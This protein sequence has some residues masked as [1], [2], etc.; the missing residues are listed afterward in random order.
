MVLTLI[1]SLVTALAIEGLGKEDALSRDNLQTQRARVQNKE[2]SYDEKIATTAR[3]GNINLPFDKGCSRGEGFYFSTTGMGCMASPFKPIPDCEAVDDTTPQACLRLRHIGRSTMDSVKVDSR[4]S[5]SK[6]TEMMASVEGGAFGVKASAS[7][8]AQARSSMTSSTIS[9][10]MYGQKHFGALEIHN[11]SLLEL[12]DEAKVLIDQGYD[13]F[14]RAFGTHFVLYMPTGSTFFGSFTIESTD[15]STSSTMSAA[16]SI[17]AKGGLWSAKGQASFK[18]STESMASNVKIKANLVCTGS[19]KCGDTSPQNPQEMMSVLGNWSSDILSEGN[20]LKMVVVPYGRSR[21]FLEA[22]AKWDSTHQDVS[23]GFGLPTEEMLTAWKLGQADADTLLH[24]VMRALDTWDGLKAGD[25]DDNL[26]TEPQWGRIDAPRARVVSTD[27]A[28]CTCPSGRTY[29]V[30]AFRNPAKPNALRGVTE[31]PDSNIS[32]AQNDLGNSPIRP[33]NNDKGKADCHLRCQSDDRC[34]AFV[35]DDTTCWL[36]TAAGPVSAAYGVHAYVLSTYG[37]PQK[38]RS[39]CASTQSNVDKWND[40]PWLAG[41]SIACS[42]GVV[43][44]PAAKDSPCEQ[45]YVFPTEETT[46]VDCMSPHLRDVMTALQQKVLAYR[47]L[48]NDISMSNLVDVQEKWNADREKVFFYRGT[49]LQELQ[50]HY[51]AIAEALDSTLLILE[52]STVERSC[53]SRSGVALEAKD[54]ELPDGAEAW[55]DPQQC[56]IAVRNRAKLTPLEV[57]DQ[58]FEFTMASHDSHGACKYLPQTTMCSVPNS[59]TSAGFF[60]PKIYR[61]NRNDMIYDQ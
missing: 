7:A 58:F 18:T 24:Q 57:S 16:A 30:G 9:Y 31:H 5:H 17:E 43:S 22:I 27:A 28:R 44:W 8:S 14:T 29:K 52:G 55:S 35:I 53:T 1:N 6:L 61:I 34:R 4:D 2:A 46:A 42:G 45:G 32:P 60:E 13:A 41:G 26:E 50:F 49:K 38:A 37:P 3:V 54:L 36:K 20:A 47:Q 48:F 12:S 21:N 25:I 15:S 59:A 40:Q 39:T 11:P 23:S 56:A 33:V 19:T 10:V 51:D